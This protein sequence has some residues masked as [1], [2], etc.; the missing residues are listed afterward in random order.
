[1]TFHGFNESDFDIFSIPDFATRMGAIRSNLRPQL[2]ALGEELAHEVRKIAFS[3]I[4]PHAAAH[5][6]RRTNPPPE[7]WVAFGRSPRGYKRYVHYRV[8]VNEGGLRVT[9]HVEDDSDDKATFAA[10]LR[11]DRDTLLDRLSMLE[12]LVW[13]S[14]RDR[15][16]GPVTGGMLTAPHLDHLSQALSTLKTADFSAGIPFDRS[17]PRLRSPIDLPPLLLE[18]MCQL[19]PLYKAALPKA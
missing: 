2:L 9:V 16:E 14:L 11:R 8:A 19:A 4:V 13:Y 3:P 12:N 10:A 15:Q 1:V 7:T 18:T 17:D 5:M 6:R